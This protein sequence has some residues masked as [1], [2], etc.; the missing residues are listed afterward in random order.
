MAY[1]IP[2]ET[3]Q[4]LQQS[5]L[6]QTIIQWNRL[7]AS[8]S[9]PH[10]LNVFKKRCLWPHLLDPPPP[11]ISL[12]FSFAPLTC[13]HQSILSSLLCCQKFPPKC[14]FT[15]Q[16]THT[17]RANKPWRKGCLVSRKKWHLGYFCFLPV[18]YC[19]LSLLFLFLSF[20]VSDGSFNAFEPWASC[21]SC[22]LSSSQNTWF[23][24]VC[25]YYSELQALLSLQSMQSLCWLLAWK[26]Q[27]FTANG[28][29]L[30]H[31]GQVPAN[32]LKLYF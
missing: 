29:N 2:S 5:F 30:V 11:S 8:V 7:P 4:Y 26:D 28:I 3:T 23:I 13:T 14:T 17:F 20:P 22:C 24:Q 10:S 12:Y 9:L 16:S 6:P 32:L 21:Y 25:P 18:F 15:P 31:P 19:V 1:D 27:T